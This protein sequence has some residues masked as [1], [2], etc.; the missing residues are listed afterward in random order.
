[1]PTTGNLQTFGDLKTLTHLFILYLQRGQARLQLVMAHQKLSL[2]RLLC[3]HLTHLGWKRKKEEL[4][5]E[6]DL[7]A[8]MMRKLTLNHELRL[9]LR[10]PTF[11]GDSPH[12][13][14]AADSRSVRE[15]RRSDCVC[16]WTSACL[17]WCPSRLP[18]PPVNPNPHGEKSP[19]CTLRTGRFSW[20]VPGWHGNLSHNTEGKK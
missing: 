3:A 12:R 1:M 8:N 11:L 15:D 14:C 5:Q 20:S 18:L 2:D 6:N 17:L 13:P 10:I 19:D 16:P 4:S 9:R 7:K